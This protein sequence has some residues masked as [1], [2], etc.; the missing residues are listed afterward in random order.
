MSAPFAIIIR[1]ASGVDLEVTSYQCP[2]CGGEVTLSAVAAGEVHVS[3][4]WRK[5]EALNGYN[6]GGIGYEV[7]HLGCVS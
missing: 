7:Y 1:T 6:S 5:P 2:I 3:R 4:K